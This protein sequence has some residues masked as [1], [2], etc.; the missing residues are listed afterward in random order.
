[1]AIA[2]YLEELQKYTIFFYFIVRVDVKATGIKDR[3]H[4]TCTMSN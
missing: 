1:M 3:V 2:P 4:R